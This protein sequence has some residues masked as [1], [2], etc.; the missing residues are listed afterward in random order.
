MPWRI[1]WRLNFRKGACL[2]HI[3]CLLCPP[4]TRPRD[5][6][7]YDRYVWAEIPDPAIHP[8]LH[9]IIT[10]CNMHGPCGPSF[11]NQPCMREGVC[12]WEFPQTFCDRTT[13]DNGGFV[14]Y[15]RRNTGRQCEG[16]GCMFGNRWVVP[17]NPVLSLRLG[18]HVNVL[19]CSSTAAVKYLSNYLFKG[20]DHATIRQEVAIDGQEPARAC[21]R[22][23]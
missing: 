11:P 15:R 16:R 6:D 18:R 14:Q 21:R 17:Y 1:S 4:E 5:A 22:A 3:S 13:E 12:R 20:A 7:S 10:T 9:S 19:I 2:M 8:K 23:L